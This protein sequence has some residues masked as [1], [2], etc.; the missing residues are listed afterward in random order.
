MFILSGFKRD[1]SFVASRFK[2]DGSLFGNSRMNGS[3]M[4]RPSKLGSYNKRIPTHACWFKRLWALSSKPEGPGGD[5][6]GKTGGRKAERGDG[7]FISVLWPVS[8]ANGHRTPC[9]RVSKQGLED[10]LKVAT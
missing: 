10:C 5:R 6:E 2:H 3:Y 8:R 7:R 1:D 4:L 9:S